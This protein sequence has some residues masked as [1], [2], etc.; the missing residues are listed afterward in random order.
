MLIG[1][2]VHNTNNI[3][4]EAEKYLKEVLILLKNKSINKYQINWENLEN[5]VYRVAKNSQTIKDTYP[6]INYAVALL[7][8]NHSYFTQAIQEDKNSEEKQLP[9][10][11]DE[12][13][14]DNIG[15]IRIPFCIG[16]ENQMELYIN[17]ITE[18]IYQ[19]NNSN[20]IGWIIDLR[21]NF[22]GNMWPMMAA[23]GSFLD[24]GSQGYF[25]DADNKSSEWRYEHG[26]VYLD[27]IVLAENKNNFS[28]F[29]K[30]KIAVLIIKQTASSGEAIA[31]LFKGY[32]NAKLFGASTYGVSTGCES[33]TLSDSSRI[34][35]AISV[36]ADR[37]KIKYGASIIPDIQCSDNE[38]LSKVIYWIN[39]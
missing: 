5:E 15:Y 35:L 7:K 37:N 14:H 10:L 24:S 22:G 16:D 34:N 32:K 2:K 27:T 28:V 26:K 9:I 3:S 13:I 8:D 29:A 11:K 21:D 33:Y 17:T 18:K 36:F 30:N 38:V 1:C 31:V 23:I 39:N 6:A 25:F 12:T 20:K 4:P 19:Q